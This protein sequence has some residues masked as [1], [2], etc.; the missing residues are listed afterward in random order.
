[1]V[2]QSETGHPHLKEMTNLDYFSS[3]FLNLLDLTRRACSQTKPSDSELSALG[4]YNALCTG[5]PVTIFISDSG[6]SVYD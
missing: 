5:Y 3:M 1:M 2:S 4:Y 6:F